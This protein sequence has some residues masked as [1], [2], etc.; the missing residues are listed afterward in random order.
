MTDN[1]SLFLD[2]GLIRKHLAEFVLQFL[3][4]SVARV[5]IATLSL[6]LP[7]ILQDVE[8]CNF[9]FGQDWLTQPHPLDNSSWLRARSKVL[10]SYSQRPARAR[11]VRFA[12]SLSSAEGWRGEATPASMR[13][14]PFQHHLPDLRKHGFRWTP[15]LALLLGLPLVE[16]SRSF[17]RF[18]I[19]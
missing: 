19:S 2:N 8:W 14:H 10:S 4:R 3:G 11:W 13:P 18:R 16:F 1:E 7:L 6:F 5:S 12:K 9:E 15:V 17:G